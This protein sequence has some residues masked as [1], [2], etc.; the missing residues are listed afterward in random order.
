[1]DMPINTQSKFA[2][3]A[4]IDDLNTEQDK[5]ERGDSQRESLK[6]SELAMYI[7]LGVV[8]AAVFGLLAMGAWVWYLKNPGW[9]SSIHRLQDM[10]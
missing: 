7:E 8:L 2:E 10:L 4:A 3:L 1:M 9:I 6:P 5:T